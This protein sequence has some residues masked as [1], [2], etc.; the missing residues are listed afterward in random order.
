[1]AVNWLARGAWPWDWALEFSDLILIFRYVRYTPDERVRPKREQM[2]I[3][4]NKALG[5]L[6][7]IDLRDL[8]EDEAR[9][10]TPWLAEPSN[11]ELLGDSIGLE[12]EL[13][14]REQSVGGFKVDILARDT[15]S[16]RYVI[17]ENQLERTNHGHLGQLLT[18]ASGYDAIAVVWLAK[19]ICDEHRKALDWLNEKTSED[20]AFFG[21]EIEL[22]K[23]GSSEPAPKFNLVSQPNDWGRTV[24]PTSAGSQEPS[25]TKLLQKEFWESMIEHFQANGTRLS[26]R[27]A[28]PQQWYSIGIG[29][30]EIHISLTVNSIQKEL[31]CGLYIKGPQSKAV[32]ARLNAEK[33]EIERELKAKLDWR[34]MPNHKASRILQLLEGDLED[35]KSWPKIFE[36]LKDRAEAFHR[37]FEKRVQDLDF[38]EEDEAA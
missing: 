13:V 26:L 37:V 5:K 23:I 17:I 12:L 7:R 34:E 22:W 19:Q 15:F 14:G 1:M 31:S 18:Y 27:K 9:H 29:K 10:F 35:R 25:E 36:W 8:W 28:R 20:L 33:A 6:S 21:L 3:H 32:Y 24:R 11:L 38:D 30:S 2:T 16:N 4:K